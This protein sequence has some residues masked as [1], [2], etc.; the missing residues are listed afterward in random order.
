MNSVALVN[1]RGN[2]KQS[3]ENGL[4]HIGGF[5]VLRSPVL[6]KPNI[7]TINDGT[8]YSCTHVETIEALIELL[9]ETDQSLSIR[10]IESD[11]QSKSALEAFQKFGYTELCKDLR[12]SG[13]DVSTVDLS[14]SNLTKL[15]RVLFIVK[16]SFFE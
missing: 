2:I 1:Y 16:T 13:F 11:S 9:L 7:C 10:I 12:K 3:L 14:N 5:G 6:I 8:G 15:A 4:N